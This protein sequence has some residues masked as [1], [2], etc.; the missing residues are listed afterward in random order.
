VGCDPGAADGIWGAKSRN[1]LARFA[2]HSKA[3]FGS[4]EPS[5]A[6]LAAI[7]SE[8]D[9]VCPAQP[10]R[11]ANRSD[12]KASAPSGAKSAKAPA[13]AQTT[14]T[15]RLETREECRARAIASG[16]TRHSGFCRERLTIC[17]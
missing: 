14:K 11:T 15:C 3:K 10:P 17:K 12:A 13:T 6:V 9:R 4:L 16:A 1:A 7:R 2:E 5:Q 8:R